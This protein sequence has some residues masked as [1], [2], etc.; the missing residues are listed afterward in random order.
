MTKQEKEQ[1]K[2]TYGTFRTAISPDGDREKLMAIK[3][4]VGVL[5][6][7]L[8]LDRRV[9][10]FNSLKIVVHDNAVTMTIG[11]KYEAWGQDVK[12]E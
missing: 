5:I 10:D 12:W 2:K 1:G 4:M 6:D 3:A 11:M 9:I 8:P 7:K